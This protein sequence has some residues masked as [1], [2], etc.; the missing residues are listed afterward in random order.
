M[1]KKR[2]KRVSNHEFPSTIEGYGYYWHHDRL[3]NIK[4]RIY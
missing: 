1:F 3:I 2:I 4:T